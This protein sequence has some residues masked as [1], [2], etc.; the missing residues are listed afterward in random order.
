MAGVG[1]LQAPTTAH[2]LLLRRRDDER[3]PGGCGNSPDARKR[4]KRE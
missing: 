2:A 3:A 1:L 4:I